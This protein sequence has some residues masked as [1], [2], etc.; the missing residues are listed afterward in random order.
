MPKILILSRY[1]TLGASSRLRMLQYAPDF[2]SS[3]WSVRIEPLL[4]DK[5]LDNI[6]KD[7][8]TICISIIRLALVV[9]CYFHRLIILLN[10][11]HYDII[12]IEK[13]LFP[14]LPSLFEKIIIL[15]KLP[16]IIDYD[17]AVFHNYDRSE[18][19]FVRKL[20]ATKLQ[21]LIAGASAVTVGNNYLLEYMV[22]QGAKYI[23]RVPTVIDISRYEVTK[24]PPSDVFRI[25]WIGSPSSA[26]YLPIIYGALQQLAQKWNI[27]FVT[28]GAPLISIPGVK[29]EQYKWTLESEGRIIQSFHVGVM[30]L[31]DTPWERGKCGYKL[32][33]YMACGRPV[34]A[35]PVGI[36]SEIVSNNVGR[37]AGLEKDWVQALDELASDQQLR[38]RLGKAARLVVE[39][40]YTKQVVA[41]K[42][43]RLFRKCAGVSR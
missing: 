1:N 34:I 27:V 36:N 2:E 35:S 13:E 28:I 26:Q 32:V 3:G 11:G 15:N 18:N 33:Q 14:F 21:R 30:P 16:Y 8:K 39:K 4:C 17:D 31:S 9:R 38:A 22:R 43:N 37:L 40:T 6:Y 42:L 25:G 24:E 20:L 7:K 5:Y 19:R 10:I 29:V 23:E 41:P 12:W